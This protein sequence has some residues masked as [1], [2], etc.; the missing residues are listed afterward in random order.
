LTGGAADLKSFFFRDLSVHLS[1]EQKMK[2]KRRAP[3]LPSQVH[4]HLSSGDA[5][6]QNV[7]DAAAR[8]R[9]READEEEGVPCAPALSPSLEGQSV[10]HDMDRPA[11]AFPSG[12]TNVVNTLVTRS[13]L[14]LSLSRPHQ[15]RQLTMSACP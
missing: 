7:L 1:C 12:K 4:T 3:P 14:P 6:M 15:S 10:E 11:R 8:G 5:M 9:E 2:N 13:P